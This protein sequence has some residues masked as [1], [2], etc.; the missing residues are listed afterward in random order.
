LPGKLTEILV[1]GIP[2]HSLALAFQRPRLALIVRPTF[3]VIF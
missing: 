1:D 2:V 3:F